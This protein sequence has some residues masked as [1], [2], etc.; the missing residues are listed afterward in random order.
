MR[1]VLKATGPCTAVLTRRRFLQM[2]GACAALA[3]ASRLIPRSALAKGVPVSTPDRMSL[4]TDM[5]MCIGCRACEVACNRVNG[6]PA[7]DRPFSETSVFE[8]RRRPTARAY[9]VVNRFA[10]QNG[11]SPVYRKMQCMH[12]SEPACVSVCPAAAMV[13]T[14]EGPVLW[15]EKVCIGCRYCM[16]ACPFSMPA[17]EYDNA[18][19]P[20]VV[21]CN[22]CYERVFKKGG[23]PACAE[24]CPVKATIFGKRDDLLQLAHKRITDSPARYA[25][26]IYGE[27]EVGGT[28][29]L[30]L[31]PAPFDSLDFP[32]VQKAGY[33]ELT[34]DFLTAVPVVLILWP[35]LLT[36]AYR[37]AHRQVAGREGGPGKA[38]LRREGG[39]D[40]H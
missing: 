21:K 4:L 27:N 17:Y 11:G 38:G 12:C 30:Y 9:T 40:E 34:W 23:L 3:A 1:D 37:L 10:G 26:L 25:N 28:S 29:W 7:P 19:G 32:E 22:M 8:E 35:L 36:G 5:T 13:K 18:F 15:D 14:P 2:T 16:L 24:S 33:G 20:R 31:S 6:L 39:H